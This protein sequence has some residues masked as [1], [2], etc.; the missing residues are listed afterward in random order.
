MPWPFK[1]LRSS[2][3]DS[4]SRSSTGR[5]STTRTSSSRRASR[6]PTRVRSKSRVRKPHCPL[7]FWSIESDDRDT[8]IDNII[9]YVAGA[10]RREQLPQTLLKKSPWAQEFI[11]PE[12]KGTASDDP[13]RFPE[14]ITAFWL[15][16]TSM[17]TELQDL[18]RFWFFTL[19]RYFYRVRFFEGPKIAREDLDVQNLDTSRVGIYL[20]EFSEEELH[21]LT[22]ARSNYGVKFYLY[23]YK[24][25][26]KSPLWTQY[27]DR[28]QSFCRSLGLQAASESPE[29]NLKEMHENL[30]SMVLHRR[31][32]DVSSHF[33]SH[34]IKNSFL[35][36]KTRAD[37]KKLDNQ[38][39]SSAVH[40]DNAVAELKREIKE[41]SRRLGHTPPLSPV[42][43]QALEVDSGI[44]AE[45]QNLGVVDQDAI[46]AILRKN[47]DS[48]Q[49]IKTLQT[50]LLELRDEF[51]RLQDVSV[52][53]D[54]LDGCR[55]LLENLPAGKS[56]YGSGALRWKGFWAKEWDH[57]IRKRRKSHPLWRLNGEEKYNM[58][59][60]KLYATLS[61]RLHDYGEQRGE[62]LH[63]DVQRVLDAIR[64]VNFDADGKIDIEAERRR[65]IS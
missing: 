20:S 23:C 28:I 59:G 61:K 34:L 8:L 37:V 30:T 45:P 54:R 35:I 55:W 36:E 14:T 5:V 32:E 7:E 49:L 12:V 39:K 50:G 26:M 42:L 48:E 1:A 64:A 52:M 15:N 51:T 6:S 56:I 25:T 19:L 29:E 13:P 57:C 9:P 17:T 27:C 65:W 3:K 24:H 4:T 16:P 46:D 33:S 10:L 63:P 22:H 44:G 38:A 11:K 60:K 18:T 43:E 40:T 31:I 2:S 62:R 58:V 47:E 53:A 41:L 21:C